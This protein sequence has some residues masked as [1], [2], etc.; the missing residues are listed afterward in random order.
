VCALDGAVFEFYISQ[1]DAKVG[2]VNVCQ[3]GEIT[4]IAMASSWGIMLPL[5]LRL[6]SY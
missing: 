1:A 6:T 2:P 5:L 4:I 3:A